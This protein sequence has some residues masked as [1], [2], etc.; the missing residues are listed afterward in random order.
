MVMEPGTQLPGVPKSV[1]EEWFDALVR[2]QIHM[3][4]YSGSVRNKIFKIL[5]ATEEDIAET[6]RRRLRT[7]R[8]GAP[9]P[10][11]IRRAERLSENLRVIRVK[12][13]EEVNSTLIEEMTRLASDE[14]VFAD[15]AIK[16]VS[17]VT[18]DTDLPAPA[19]LRNVATRRPFQGRTLREWARKIQA[20][21]LARLDSAIKIGVVQGETNDQIA[22]RLVGS[23]RL[24]G[25]D[26]VTQ[27]TR[28]QAEA[29]T[30][31]AT[32]HIGNR[33]RQEFYQENSDLFDN[34][35]YVATLDSRTT[36][37]CRAN[38]G[39]VFAL[40]QGP[41]PPLHHQCRST[42]VPV[43]AGDT[44]GD[45]PAKPTTERQ[46]LREYSERNNITRPSTRDGLP[47]GHKGRFDQ[48]KRERVREMTGQ[49]P[50]KTSYQQWLK[51]QSTEFQE[52]VL[53]K[54]KAKL[55]REGG[56]DLPKFVN[57]RGDELTL[58]QL[59]RRDAAAFRRA[60]LDPD[61][62]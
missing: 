7:L 13:W 51:G 17:P 57:R 26:G 42:R 31:T 32:N 28:N 2:H 52:D 21:D 8:P 59:A 14:V 41:I 53:G 35:Q 4:R 54:T 40:G 44:L 29:L 46:L 37:V 50:G 3:M 56:L 18:L 45:R 16:T 47:R 6:T 61:E 27:V 36:P 1:N 34:E 38:D 11:A 55:F 60:G 25:R 12:A 33:V 15:R 43:L 20:D 49:V 48:Y 10:A 58:P 24:R 23:A 22:R 30:R 5:D 9:T 62:F 19:L 39:Q